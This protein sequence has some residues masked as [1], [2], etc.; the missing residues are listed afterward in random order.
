MEETEASASFS[1]ILWPDPR[2]GPWGI[3]ANWELIDGRPECVGLNI[4]HGAVQ[5]TRSHLAY[6]PLSKKPLTP[7]QATHIAQMPIATIIAKLRVA[8]REHWRCNRSELRQALT[9][10]EGQVD[11]AWLQGMKELIGQ[12]SPFEQQAATVGAPRR[13]AM[14]HYVEVAEIYLAAW[15][16]GDQPTQA[17]ASHFGVSRSAAAKW[18]AKARSEELLSPGT[19]GRA[20]A[21]AGQRLV[22]LRKRVKKDEAIGRNVPDTHT[23]RSPR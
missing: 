16:G 7:I 2:R 17:V 15:Q 6:R 20:G 3:Q 19:H 5:G 4:W 22:Q 21:E 11:D 9:N 1:Q 10:H 14:A 8:A 13:Y 18:V 12:D 23:K